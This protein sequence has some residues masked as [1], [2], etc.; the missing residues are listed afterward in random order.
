[1]LLFDLEVFRLKFSQIR[2]GIVSARFWFVFVFFLSVV[3]CV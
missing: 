2:I 1:M 3:V